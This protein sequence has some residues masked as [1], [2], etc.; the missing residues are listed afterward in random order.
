MI[1]AKLIFLLFFLLL[2]TLNANA[3]LALGA[4]IPFIGSSIL[5]IFLGILSIIGFFIYPILLA[6]QFFKKKNKS[7][8][9]N[10][11]KN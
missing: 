3:Y 6:F 10:K 2:Y 7:A 9:K 4:I 1:I 8:K 5:F 11:S